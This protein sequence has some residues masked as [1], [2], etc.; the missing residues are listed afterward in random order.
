MATDDPQGIRWDCR[1][2]LP[3]T[4]APLAAI[5]QGPMIT[6][7]RP[8]PKR[9]WR[10]PSKGDR[11]SCNGCATTSSS[12]RRSV[13]VPPYDF[14]GRDIKNHLLMFILMIDDLAVANLVD[15]SGF[16]QAIEPRRHPIDS[17]TRNCFH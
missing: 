14:R 1:P 10:A 6:S 15:G 17:E 13:R 7:H 16:Q 12:G 9:C 4:R 8:E 3:P 11:L 2:C 5:G